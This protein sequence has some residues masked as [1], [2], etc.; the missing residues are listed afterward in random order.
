MKQLT[1]IFQKNFNSLMSIQEVDELK[2]AVE[3]LI[4]GIN[5]MDQRKVKLNLMN[6][7]TLPAVQQY[8]TN[9]MF[10]YQGMG[11]I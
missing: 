11:V 2:S 9:S 4:K 6:L 1:S 5:Q 3:S 10:K 8:I 7:E